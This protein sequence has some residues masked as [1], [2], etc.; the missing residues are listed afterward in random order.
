[1]GAAKSLT[2]TELE[3]TLEHISTRK[4][5][6]RAERVNDFAP[7]MIKNLLRKVVLISG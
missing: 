2:N 1:M 7:R 3:H 6:A 4:F 5:A